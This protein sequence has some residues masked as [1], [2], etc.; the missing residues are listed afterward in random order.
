MSV[1]HLGRNVSVG[2]STRGGDPGTAIVER[3]A[4]TEAELVV[5]GCRGRGHVAGHLPRLG[6]RRGCCQAA[7]R[8]CPAE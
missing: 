4:E 3:Q 7:C 2:S 8:G 1:L 5:M 6:L